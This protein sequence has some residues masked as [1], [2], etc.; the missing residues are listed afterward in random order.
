MTDLRS[1]LQRLE[2][3]LWS[4]WREQATR[5]QHNELTNSEVHYLY[6]L[7]GWEQTG[8]RLTELA[9]SLQVSKASAS[10][11]VRK[12]EQQGYLVRRQ[13]DQDARAQRLFPSSKALSLKHEE[14]RIYQAA[15]SHFAEVLSHAELNQLTSL[16]AK[17]CQDL[18]L[19]DTQP[20]SL[21]A[22]PY[23]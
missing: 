7:L 14:P 11:M 4:Q 10:A 2:W 12:L 1:S 3:H 17:A 13:C 5:H 19:G 16:L 23:E 6:A 9:E 22:Q 20:P 15:L 21:N 8:V 18:S